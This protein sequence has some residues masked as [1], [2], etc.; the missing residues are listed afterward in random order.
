MTQSNKV[1]IKHIQLL[2][3]LKGG[4]PLERQTQT[5]TRIKSNKGT[6]C[7]EHATNPRSISELCNVF[8]M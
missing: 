4:R 5:F 6:Y 8:E 7:L 3:I 2:K 1:R